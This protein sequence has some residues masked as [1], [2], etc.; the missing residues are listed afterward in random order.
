VARLFAIDAWQ[1]T[2]FLFMTLVEAYLACEVLSALRLFDRLILLNLLRFGFSLRALGF[3][4]SFRRYHNSL[5]NH[6]I[7]FL[8]ILGLV[9]KLFAFIA[10]RAI[11]RLVARFVA[12]LAR[13][14]AVFE[15]MAIL[16]TDGAV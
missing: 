11:F 13:F 4:I 1:L 14:F 15:E 5:L 16:I 9:S 7:G 8:A 2:F 12:F 10:L 6:S 3:L